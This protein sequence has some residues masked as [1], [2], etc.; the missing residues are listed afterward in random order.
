MNGLALCIFLILV[1]TGAFLLTWGIIT[2]QYC[3]ATSSFGMAPAVVISF[4]SGL[5]ML[6]FASAVWVD[7][8]REEE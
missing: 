7:I 5:L 2:L 4:S 1:V 3:I 6:V 8:K